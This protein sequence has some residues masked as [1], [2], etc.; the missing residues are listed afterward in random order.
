MADDEVARVVREMLAVIP[1][2]CSWLLPVTGRGGQV[3]DF[4]IGATSGS[5]NDIYHRGT[6]RIDRLLSESYPGIVGGPL[7]QAALI[8]PEDDTCTLAA[9]IR[10]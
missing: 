6:S 2:G 8:L 9:R 4:R 5:G 10:P 1:A 7:W 3:V